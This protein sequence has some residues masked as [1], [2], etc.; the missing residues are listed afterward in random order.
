VNAGRHVVQFYSHDAEL[1]DRVSDYLLGALEGGG[2][3]IVIATAAH[4]R[5]FERRLAAAG[6]DLVKAARSGAYL[7]FD[8]ADTIRELMAADGTE[9]PDQ[10]RFDRVIG[11]LIS[12]AASGGGPVCAYGEMVALLWD[13]GLVNAA[14]RLEAMWNELGMRHAFSLFCGYSAGSVAGQGHGDAFAEVCRL[15]QEIVVSSTAAGPGAMRSFAFSA[16][17]PAAARHFAVAVLER[18]GAAELTDDAALVVTE[19]AAN[20]IVHAHSGFTVTLS[21]PGDAIRISVRDSR[22]LP[23]GAETQ[24]PTAQLHGLGAVNALAS[25]WGVEPFGPAGKAVWVELRR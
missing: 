3:A 9:G 23:A 5:A 4:T 15:H 10:G 25:R 12:G 2:V 14:I 11:G 18:W 20:S 21:A 17:A 6:V 24:L 7:A 19:L 22:P 13:T 16:E 1:A 8:A